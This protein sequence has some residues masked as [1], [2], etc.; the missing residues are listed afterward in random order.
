MSELSLRERIE[1]LEAENADL[2]HQL[3]HVADNDFI[4]ALHARLGCT[5]SEGRFLWL[6]WDC[7]LKSRD[8]IFSALYSDRID[9]P[10][11]QIVNVFAAKIRRAIKTIDANLTTHWAAGYQLMPEDRARI[12]A[13]IGIEVRP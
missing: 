7:R 9:P 11:I 5:R 10:N 4:Q 1:Y 12:A 6:L 8:A 3:R 13:Y 2:R